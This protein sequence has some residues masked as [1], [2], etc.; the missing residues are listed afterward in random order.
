[1]G[2]FFVPFDRERNQK[3]SKKNSHSEYHYKLCDG[4]SKRY[5][6]SI[7]TFRRVDR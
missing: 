6:W 4:G 3:N 5:R 7:W 1:M 2:V